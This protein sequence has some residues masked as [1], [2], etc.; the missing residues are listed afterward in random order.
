MIPTSVVAA[1]VV[2]TFA[3]Y[4]DLPTKFW[5]IA[6]A[7][8]ELDTLKPKHDRAVVLLHGLLPRPLHPERAE[9]PDVHSWQTPNGEL[10]KTLTD[11]FDVFGFSYAQT[12]P[13]DTVALSSGLRNGVA[14]LKKA[15]Y[16][17][18]ALVG[19]SAGGI[20][21]RRF[22][23]LYPDAGV[24][25]LVTVA[26]P[27]LGSGW[28]RLPNFTLPKT[29]VAFIQSLLPEIREAV[30]KER[31]CTIADGVEVCCV[32][33]KLPRLDNDTVVGLKSQ[34]PEELQKQGVAAVLVGCNHFEAMTCD[35][36]V[37]ALQELLKGRVV[38]W[39]DDEVTKA[40]TALFGDK[41]KDKR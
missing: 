6:P 27:F 7:V 28:A 34:W 33:C 40:R 12:G 11:E 41:S 23:E 5:G 25:K 36:G 39:K 15:G 10:V 2:V 13:V 30:T 32:V 1:A 21:A 29:Q 37:K 14:A 4:V 8:Q 35:K 3:P 38:R 24:T 18:I 17:E 22:V 16:K 9:Q 26:A 20:I 31:V 19:H